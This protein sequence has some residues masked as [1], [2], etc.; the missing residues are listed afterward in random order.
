MIYKIE[1]TDDPDEPGQPGV[2]EVADL[3]IEPSSRWTPMSPP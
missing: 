2:S 3:S 1:V